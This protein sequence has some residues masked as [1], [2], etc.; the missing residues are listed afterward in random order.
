MDESLHPSTLSE[1]LDRTVHIY[2]SRFLV[3]LGIA[4]VPTAAVLV[5]LCGLV[6]AA[7]WLG[8]KGTD[9]AGGAATVLAVGGL[10]LVAGPVWAAVT[11]LATAAMS[12]AASRW[13]LDAERVTI[14]GAYRKAWRRGWR[15]LGLYLLEVLLIWGAPAAVWFLLAAAAAGLAVTMRAAGTDALLGFGAFAAIVGLVAYGIWMLL[16][17]SLAFAASVVEGI[18]IGP[19]L[20]RGA[21]LSTGSR[22]R[23]FL[24]YLL[25][26]VLNY[27]IMIAVTV[28]LSIVL[29][30]IPGVNS[31]Q[32]AQTMGAV[33]LVA[34]YGT[35]FAAQALTKPVYA[36]ALVLFYYDQRIRKEGFDI[37]WMMQRA[38]LEAPTPAAVEAHPWIPV[39][40][41]GP[42]AEPWPE[43]SAASALHT[44]TAVSPPV[45]TA[46]AP[47]GETG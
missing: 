38:G 7:A 6:L 28:P 24:L 2:R 3:F 17:L 43:I 15:Y 22:G 35:G 45:E 40:Q 13:N 5:P 34:V 11:A 31:P 36:I 42:I 16:R 47:S 9:L 4:A 23:I 19:S 8:A 30:F 39:P 44:E 12:D 41:T 46:P 1:I 27:L 26:T 32:H 18:G 37:E 33:V 20:R 14:R 21:E 25:G 10:L 29:A